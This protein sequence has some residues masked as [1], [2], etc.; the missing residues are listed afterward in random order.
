MDDDSGIFKI[1]AGV[2]VL[3]I[4]F[5]VFGFDNIIKKIKVNDIIDDNGKKYSKEID[6]Y[7]DDLENYATKIK[8][9]NLNDLET[10]MLVMEDQWKLYKYEKNDEFICGYPRVSLKNDGYGVCYGFA[11]D[12]TAKMNAINPEYD[13]KNIFCYLDDDKYE[14]VCVVS[15]DREAIEISDEIEESDIPKKYGNH[16]ISSI[17]I[18]GEEYILTIDPTNLTIGLLNDGEIYLFNNDSNE[19]LIYKKTG[20]YV[21]GGDNYY[22]YHDT[23]YE[24]DES[25]EELSDMYSYEEQKDALNSVHEKVYLK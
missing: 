13:A 22:S 12:F 14:D 17:K 24:M 1:I 19:S 20:N 21:L 23:F 7:N 25:V 3:I 2:V 18:P 11:D 6:D 15:I 10:I 4:A 9:L 8:N 5:K 16:V